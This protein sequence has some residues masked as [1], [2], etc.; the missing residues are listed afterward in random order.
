MFNFKSIALAFIFLMPLNVL[1]DVFL[2][3]FI[4]REK[5]INIIYGWLEYIIEDEFYIPSEKQA[6]VEIILKAT[7]NE[8]TFILPGSLA[9]LSRI[10]G[11]EELLKNLLNWINK[12]GYQTALIILTNIISSLN[13]QNTELHHEDITRHINFYNYY[14]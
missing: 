11:N 10:I 12:Y 4:N 6:L 9:I 5:N 14:F 13:Y 2:E 8:L 3:Q 7:V 1:S